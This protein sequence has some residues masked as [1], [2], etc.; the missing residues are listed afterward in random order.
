MRNQLMHWRS[1]FASVMLGLA[2]AAPAADMQVAFGANGLASLRLGDHEL[3]GNGAVSVRRVVLANAVRNRN[4]EP[5]ATMYHADRRTFRDGRTM[6]FEV[7][8]ETMANQLAQLHEWGKLTIAY[9]SSTD[10]RLDIVVTIENTS[11]E[12]IEYLE[13]DL[14]ALTLP[15]QVQSRLVSSIP[16]F[17]RSNANLDGPDV[18]VTDFDGG[19]LIFAG[20]TFEV[21]LVQ[22]ISAR[23]GAQIVS[24]AVGSPN[25]GSEVLDK[26][27]NVYPIAAGETARFE[28]TMRFVP[29]GTDPFTAVRDVLEAYGEAV[30]M[31]M[32]WPD[33][34]PILSVHVADGRRNR[35][36]PRGWKQTV[37]LPETWHILEDEDHAAFRAAVLR[38]AENI[39]RV[40]RRSGAQGA[41]VWQIEGMQEP[42]HSYYGEPRI[43][44][45]VAPEMDA[46]AD[47][48]FRILRDSGLR[49]GVT[50]RPVIQAPF[51]PE[52]GKHSGALEGVV[53]WQQM[54]E[55]AKRADWSVQFRNL[56]WLDSI[57]EP[58]RNFYHADEAW[59]MLL[60]LDNKIRYAKQRW[61]ATLFY[62]DANNAYRPRVRGETAENW[63]GRPISARVIEQLQ[64]RHPDCQIIAEHQNFRYWTSGAQYVQPPH[65][66]Q[67]V[68][69]REVRI[70]YPDAMSVIA[71]VAEDS[72]F[73]NEQRFA[74]YT[75][76][77]VN[78]DTLLT[79][80]WFGG[81]YGLLDALFGPA[82]MLAPFQIRVLASSIEA[83]GETLTDA[84]ALQAW[85]KDRMPTTRAI[86]PR[87]AFVRYL[88][89]V[90]VAELS[91]VHEAIFAAD[92]VLAWSV[93][94]HR[95]HPGFWNDAVV[96]IEMPQAYAQRFA[97]PEKDALR[98]LIG[99][100][101]DQE[102]VIA[103][104]LNVAQLGIGA[105]QPDDVIVTHLNSVFQTERITP[106]TA[107]STNA[108]TL[109]AAAPSDIDDLMGSLLTEIGRQDQR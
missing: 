54:R 12:T 46:I 32:H 103:V 76:G 100:A 22:Q 66:G 106:P 55:A 35:A 14:A 79:H 11:D 36:N 108:P 107:P 47:E 61:G 49:V 33:R 23:D 4:N 28:L 39:V 67:S 3:L 25:G 38:G 5:D 64:R 99:N 74:H 8:F 60:R 15:G 88:P 17:M 80:G 31:I 105:R 41:I 71:A 21:P 16:G 84:A 34:R 26:L 6:P 53:D 50:L 13:L 63:G 62:L 24:L 83:N 91:A 94:E 58:L 48:M 40:A 81:H 56:S 75:N 29:A 52:K 82:A 2:I 96:N 30:P 104:K 1:L 102:R 109:I 37:G 7:Y 77:V 90:P 93:V 92:G 97:D 85:L 86:R 45:Y 87:R 78:G 10:R 9:A 95:E 59:S 19:R 98:L 69:P 101:A 44:P 72:V 70:A 27:W 89:T 68:T 57:P 65:F 73:L 20:R 42:G 18:R 43:L 51:D